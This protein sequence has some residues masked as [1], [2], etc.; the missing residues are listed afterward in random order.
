MSL[1][2]SREGEKKEKNSFS[3]LASEQNRKAAAKVAA[4]VV[5]F[6]V[7]IAGCALATVAS[8]VHQPPAVVCSVLRHPPRSLVGPRV[9]RILAV[10]QITL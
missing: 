7:M 4:S 3:F 6:D 1:T 8:S 9:S 10:L 2:P 5:S